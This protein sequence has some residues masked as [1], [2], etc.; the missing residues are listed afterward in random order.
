VD[1]SFVNS[2]VSVQLISLW[3]QSKSIAA[4]AYPA[5]AVR[6]YRSI[7][8]RAVWDNEHE[9]GQYWDWRSLWFKSIYDQSHSECRL[10]FVRQHDS[11]NLLTFW[12]WVIDEHDDRERPSTG[13]NVTVRKHGSPKSFVWWYR[14]VHESYRDRQ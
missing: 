5:V 12:R 11:S 14:N 10:L 9:P 1:H 7:R 4:T 2:H 13:G 8:R 6:E 3:I